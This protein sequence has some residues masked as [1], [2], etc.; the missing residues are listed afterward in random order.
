MEKKITVAKKGIGRVNALKKNGNA[1]PAENTLGGSN[2]NR[3]ID[4]AGVIQK[5]EHKDMEFVYQVISFCS[6]RNVCGIN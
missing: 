6:K 3:N 1:M 2:V 4:V 5:V